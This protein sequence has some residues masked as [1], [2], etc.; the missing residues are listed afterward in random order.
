MKKAILAVLALAFAACLYV[1]AAAETFTSSDGVLSIEL[2][3]ENWKEV[4]DTTKW[5]VL[6]DGSNVLTIDHFSNGEKLPDMSVADTHYVNVYQAVFSTQNE[7]FI[8]TGSVVDAAKISEVTNMI[9]SAKVLKYDTKT[10][11]RKEDTPSISEFSVVPVDK[12][13]YVT[14]DGLNVRAGCS[15][16][17]LIL[18][19]Y[20]NGAA[21]HVTGVVQRNGEDY[22]WYQIAYGNATG[23]V[24]AGF[25]SDD[26]P[27]QKK[28]PG[29]DYTGNV[30]TAYAEDGTAVTLYEATNGYWY[31]NDGTCYVRQSDTEFQ[32][33]EGTKRLSTY[34]P[35]PQP[36]AS[37]TVYD[38]AGSAFTLYEGSDGLW[39]DESGTAYTRLSDT[40][41]QAYEGT[42]RVFT[43]DN[44]SQGSSEAAP[45]GVVTAYEEDG[46]AVTLYESADGLWYDNDGTA[47]TRHSDTDFQVYEGNRHLTVY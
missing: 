25:L 17:D 22:G 9:L 11:V 38:E 33:Y 27:E 15:T 7:V 34:P 23:Y 39:Y 28:D 19:T 44:S 45:N 10:A 16:D 26:E 46:T 42:K 24:S 8:I 4:E 18:G 14:G 41:F 36:S 2:P 3:N 5:I 13:M 29:P 47:Y 32:V 20:D 43:Y 30:K 35:A 37:V 21:V 12:T 6:S 1:P 31:D 40:E